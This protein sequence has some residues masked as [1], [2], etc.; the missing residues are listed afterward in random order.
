MSVSY[1]KSHTADPLHKCQFCNKTFTNLTKY[2]Y[3]RRTHLN[4]DAPAAPTTPFTVDSEGISQVFLHLIRHFNP[5]CACC[6]L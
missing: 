6:L 5:T 3:H 2:L 1:R 4:R